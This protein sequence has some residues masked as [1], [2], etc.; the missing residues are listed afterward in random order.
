MATELLEHNLLLNV[1]LR[2]FVLMALAGSIALI[3]R[4]R[5]AALNH[6]VWAL[7]FYGCLLAPIVTLLVPNWSL[8]LLPPPDSASV[9]SAMPPAPASAVARADAINVPRQLV[10]RAPALPLA[11]VES[12]PRA[13]TQPAVPR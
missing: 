10:A 12:D 6:H 1:A 5:S 3:C 2:S 9:A 7:G 4:R 13:A 11:P 8:P